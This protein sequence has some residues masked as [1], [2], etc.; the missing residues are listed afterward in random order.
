MTS[1][2]R[3]LSTVD[4]FRCHDNNNDNDNDNDNDDNN[5]GNSSSFNSDKI[6]TMEAFNSI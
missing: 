6:A 4:V 5:I 1:F 2:F 3:L